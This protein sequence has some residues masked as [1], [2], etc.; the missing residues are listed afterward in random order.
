[1]SAPDASAMPDLSSILVVYGP[2]GILS[3]LACLVAA[4][5]YRD[6]KDEREVHTKAL[7]A[8]NEKHE[9]ELATARADMAKLEERYIAK[10]ET[11]IEKYHQLAESLNRVVESALKRYPRQSGGSHGGP[12]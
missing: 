5:L 4:K 1:M 8:L 6:G 10:T 3:L 9:E 7:A 2:L 12:D 11:Q